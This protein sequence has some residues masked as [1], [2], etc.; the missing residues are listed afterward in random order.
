MSSTGGSPLSQWSTSKICEIISCLISLYP[1][2]QD[3]NMNESVAPSRVLGV[4]DEH[5]TRRDLEKLFEEYGPIEKLK[6]S[7]TVR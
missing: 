3:V 4:L 7:K 1:L 6:L 5:F 2:K